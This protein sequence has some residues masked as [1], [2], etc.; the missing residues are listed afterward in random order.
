MELL[1]SSLIC[2]Y[3]QVIACSTGRQLDIHKNPVHCQDWW[4]Q[5]VE[6]YWN[7]I[8]QEYDI[9]GVIPAVNPYM[10]ELMAS[11][12]L[13]HLRWRLKDPEADG[14]LYFNKSNY[15]FKNICFIDPNEKKTQMQQKIK[16][17]FVITSSHWSCCWWCSCVC[18]CKNSPTWMCPC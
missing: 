13:S 6:D 16:G 17:I 18:N 15:S 14:K 5:V 7:S 2:L 10:I 1:T 9:V 8:L 4:A 11:E 3:C 12:L